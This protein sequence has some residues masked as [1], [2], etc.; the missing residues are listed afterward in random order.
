M[1]GSKKLALQVYSFTAE[2]TGRIVLM[3]S[4]TCT[5]ILCRESNPVLSAC[6]ADVI[7]NRYTTEADEN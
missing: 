7:L 1:G 4:S 3:K 6:E 2:R 5:P